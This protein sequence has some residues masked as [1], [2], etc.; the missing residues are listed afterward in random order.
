MATNA[1]ITYICGH[2]YG[3]TKR[4]L[5]INYAITKGPYPIS[6]TLG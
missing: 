1:V 2:W 5:A 6:R 4:P 3:I